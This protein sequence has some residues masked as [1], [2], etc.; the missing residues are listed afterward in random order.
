MKHII[1]LLISLPL[2]AAD[3]LSVIP[4]SETLTV[5]EPGSYTVYSSGG[6]ASFNS[7]PP[8]LP[9]NPAGDYV[10]LK[11]DGYLVSFV[12]YGSISDSSV[13]SSAR[14]ADL[15]SGDCVSGM[16]ASLFQLVLRSSRIN[17][18]PHSADDYF[19]SGE[20]DPEPENSAAQTVYTR[21]SL[22]KANLQA[23]RY[24]VTDKYGRIL[25]QSMPEEEI[26]SL[27]PGL[28]FIHRE[29]GQFLLFWSVP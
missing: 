10:L 25:G 24:V 12:C 18:F 16:P 11:R 20:E 5:S 29:N 22:Q 21:S 8:N 23:S 28:Y 6:V 19:W 1:I 26:L 2:A 15:W 27:R 3:I 17:F 14:E 7:I 4:D 13:L 9:L